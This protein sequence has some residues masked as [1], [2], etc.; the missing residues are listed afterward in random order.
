MAALGGAGLFVL[1]GLGLARRASAE[2]RWIEA[3]AGG[4]GG[5]DGANA[6][7]V[8]VW[9]GGFTPN[10]DVMVFPY[11]NNQIMQHRFAT[12]DMYGVVHIEHLSVFNVNC[13]KT[14]AFYACDQVA[15]NQKCLQWRGTP[16]PYVTSEPSWTYVACK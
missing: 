7:E 3:C 8:E 6:Q 9:A 2:D 12:A 1:A 15:M 16:S 11:Y 4:P 13:N 10:K 5:C 14:L